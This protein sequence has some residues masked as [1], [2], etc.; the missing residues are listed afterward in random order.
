MDTDGHVNQN[1]FF[2]H[3]EPEDKDK[4]V[5]ANHNAF[6]TFGYHVL[7]FS[8]VAVPLF[9]LF[10]AHECTSIGYFLSSSLRCGSETEFNPISPIWSRLFLVIYYY[11]LCKYCNFM[12]S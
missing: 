2:G 11:L 6:L 12:E 3:L 10:A 1:Y 9:A 7:V 4:D 5:V 8:M